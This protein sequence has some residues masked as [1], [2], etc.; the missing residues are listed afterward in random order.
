MFVNHQAEDHWNRWIHQKL[1]RTQVLH[2]QKC[3]SKCPTRNVSL[4]NNWGRSGT[5][6]RSCGMETRLSQFT[7]WDNIGPGQL[8][9]QKLKYPP[10]HYLNQ[11]PS[12]YHSSCRH[13]SM[14]VTMNQAQCRHQTQSRRPLPPGLHHDVSPLTN[15]SFENTLTLRACRVR[16]QLLPSYH[17]A[18][19]TSTVLDLKE[20]TDGL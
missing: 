11:V 1:R 19:L 20:W 2:S 3:T 18:I 15:V 6:T 10:V 8:L 5:D 16:S 12:E 9:E 13:L 17:S 7:N 4:P 14:F